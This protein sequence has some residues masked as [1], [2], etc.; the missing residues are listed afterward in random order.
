VLVNPAENSETILREVRE[1]AR[2]IGLRIQILNLSTIREIDTVFAA[3]ARERPDAL[4]VA[5]DQFLSR[6]FLD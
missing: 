2:A 5:P 3:F 1:A 6:A 4:F